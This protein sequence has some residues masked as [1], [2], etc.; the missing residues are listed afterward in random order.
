MDIMSYLQSLVEV[1]DKIVESHNLLILGNV[2]IADHVIRTAQQLNRSSSVVPKSIWLRT[3]FFPQK[4]ISNLLCF[5]VVKGVEQSFKWKGQDIK[6][7]LINGINKYKNIASRIQNF[8]NIPAVQLIITIIEGG[9]EK[10]ATDLVVSTGATKE[11]IAPLLEKA[12][13]LIW[14]SADSKRRCENLVGLYSKALEQ[15]EEMLNRAPLW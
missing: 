12:Q 9:V 15:W 10:G 1:E 2:N 13:N 11:T 5:L 7:E 14:L 4:I 8:E 3:F 6:Q